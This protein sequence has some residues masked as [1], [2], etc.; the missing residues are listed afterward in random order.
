MATITARKRADGVKYTAQ[1][2][3]KKDG[4]VYHTEA[5]TFERKALAKAWG[6]KREAE[7][8]EQGGATAFGATGLAGS[9]SKTLLKTVIEKYLDEHTL[10]GDLGKTKR[11]T[12]R[13]IA[14][15]EL[16]KVAAAD[17]RSAHLVAFGRERLL[18]DGI[19]PQTLGND[20]AHL[21]AVF[22]I[23][24]AAW[25]YPLDYAQI[26]EALTVLKKMNMVKRSDERDRRPTL[27]ELDKL[28]THFE[29]MQK[30]KP[31]SINM[32]RV[33]MF[34][35]FSTRRDA[36]I[37]RI[38]W[39]DVIENRQAVIVRDMK[40]PGQKQGN[41]VECHLP[42]RAWQILQAMPRV[43]G[44]ERIFPYHPSSVSTAFT[45]ACKLLGIEDLHLHDLRHE[46]ISHLFELDWQIP[47][48]A[49][50]SGHT[51]WNSLR[52]YTKIEAMGDRYAESYLLARAM[53]CEVSLGKRVEQ[54][55]K[56][57]Y[58]GRIR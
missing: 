30:R 2:R 27:A 43:D 41:D 38:T 58:T 29:A 48:V 18:Q 36:E 31:T 44:C 51:N 1:I 6:E 42:G 15:S 4:K 26:T 25:G 33:V 13:R 17:V 50:V 8:R 55:G 19:M 57:H 46:G 11:Q 10:F 3:L 45:K 20:L 5:K 49:S 16:G 21:S 39:A 22:R 54:W 47:R 23:A 56:R 9:T 40:N 52:R 28:M 12:L 53:A 14:E 7:L 35:L 34:A 24:K 32:P 37:C